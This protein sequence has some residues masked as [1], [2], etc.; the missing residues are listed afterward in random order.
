MSGWFLVVDDDDDDDESGDCL[1][2]FSIFLCCK[3]MVLLENKN[4]KIII[5]TNLKYPK[6][7]CL[8]SNKLSFVLLNG[9]MEEPIIVKINIYD[10]RQL[11]HV[12]A[13]I[14]T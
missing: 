1:P 6:I 8:N 5:F 3:N 13:S 11:I 7:Q 4:P 2:S 9:F 10:P 14:P 12:P